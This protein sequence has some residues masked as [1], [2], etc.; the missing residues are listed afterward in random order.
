MG[1]ALSHPVRKESFQSD[2]FLISH[3]EPSRPHHHN[4]KTS[5]RTVG[6]AEPLRRHY[7]K[8][9]AQKLRME[10]VDTMGVRGKER[11]SAYRQ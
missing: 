3:P 11:W 1:C 4:N 8:T 6:R 9:A 7:Y 5:L 10:Q 2:R